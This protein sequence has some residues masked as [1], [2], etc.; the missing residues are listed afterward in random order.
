MRSSVK[1]NSQM[2]PIV[3]T[4]PLGLSTN[5]SPS[6]DFSFVDA[7]YY[8]FDSG[9]ADFVYVPN[10][11]RVF[12]LD[13]GSAEVLREVRGNDDEEKRRLAELELLFAPEIGDSPP[14]VS[15]HALSLAIAQ[16]CNLGCSYCYAEGG[17]FGG[18]A[19][20][21]TSDV[22]FAAVDRLVENVAPGERANLAF[23]GG[24][25]LFNRAVLQDATRYAVDAAAAAGVEIGFSITTNGTL[26]TQEDAD[27]FE[28]YGFAITVSLDGIGSAHD[29]LRP[30][31]SGRGSFEHVIARVAPLLRQQRTMQVSAR[32]TVTPENVELPNTLITLFD[33][34]FHSVG[35]SPMLASPNGQGQMQAEQ[36]DEMLAQ[37]TS[38]GR[39]F[40]AAV[41]EGIRFPFT[42]MVNAMRE[43]H[44]GAHR[45]YPCGAGAGYFGVSADGGLFACHRFVGDSTGAMGHV[46]S[47]V[48]G[49]A[50]RRWMQDRHVH[51]QDPCSDCW[52]RY[53]CGGG[54]HHEVIK[55]G[56][57]ACEYIRGWLAYCFKAYVRLGQTCPQYFDAGNHPTSN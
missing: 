34:G 39:M 37:M 48:N 57:P 6:T 41:T 8:L 21:M 35:F 46:N 40:E 9:G 27:F 38:C 47:G 10:G 16:K 24:E 55:R 56:R 18:A 53:L 54:C 42:N 4:D 32:V 20:S 51:F 11:S 33:L 23:L 3:E 22:A 1:G 49:H 17:E 52:A 13:K 44:R 30:F 45:P 14:E 28:H 25:P 15:L 2:L 36:L 50:Q 26:L 31:K 19:K 43:I 12:R 7:N 29:E 5:R